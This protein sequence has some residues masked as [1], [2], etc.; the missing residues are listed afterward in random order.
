MPER[1]P[2]EEI[3]SSESIAG[4]LKWLPNGLLVH[5]GKSTS[6]TD[7]P[8]AALDATE[9]TEGHIVPDIP[10][11]QL[12]YVLDS[13]LLLESLR[14]F[15]MYRLMNIPQ[16]ARLNDPDNAPENSVRADNFN[17]TRF[18]HS[19]DVCAL[20]SVIGYNAKL[21]TAQITALQI[22]TATHDVLTPAGGDTTKIID[23]MA[24][25]E[26]LHYP[27]HLQ[28]EKVRSF[29][30]E[31]EIDASLI[32]DTVVG[33]GLLSDIRD[34]ADKLAYTARD[35]DH[36]IAPAD[37][38]FKKTEMLPSR[39]P[40][41]DYMAT[42]PNNGAGALNLWQDVKVID[43][44]MVVTDADKLYAFLK[45]RALMFRQLYTNPKARYNEALL[46]SSLMKYLYSES[47][48]T[49][50]NMIDP[51]KGEA[52]DQNLEDLIREWFGVENT[53]IW[54]NNCEP[55]Y[56][57]FKTE[58]DAKEREKEILLSGNPFVQ[59][60]D[61]SRFFKPGTHFL[62]P[63]TNNDGYGT[64]AEIYPERHADIESTGKHPEP[65]RVYYFKE[66]PHNRDLEL[67]YKWRLAQV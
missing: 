60:E 55:S 19:L 37:L 56:E 14:E 6:E 7:T 46:Y 30:D 15:G 16:L 67:F 42:L 10:R 22:G 49:R 4:A 27:S 53:D 51:D 59:V 39:K 45:I 20:A 57:V 64:F 32:L 54:Y 26:D 5:G 41:L 47:I 52:Y 21:N 58:K 50:R 1:P 31:N 11:T 62:V 25:D 36:F 66:P 24:F 2:Q 34:F 43:G 23:R 8:Q 65:I 29:C 61:V 9:S 13:G 40:I 63:N 44:K 48:L 17:H 18:A 3:I 33:K 38:L 12:G 28:S 35:L